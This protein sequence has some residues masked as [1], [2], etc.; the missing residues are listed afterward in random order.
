LE[1]KRSAPF[2]N[3]TTRR[4]TLK[5]LQE[6]KYPFLDLDLSGMLDDLLE[7]GIIQLLE[8]KRLEEVGR[9]FDPK[10]YCYHRMVSHP[11]ENCIMIKELIM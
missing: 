9:T 2:K 1:E 6:K 11:L 8:P 5:E 10:Y 3:T 7:K 4:P